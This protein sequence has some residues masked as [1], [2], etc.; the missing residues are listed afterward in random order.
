MN[1]ASRLEA[2]APPDTILISKVTYECVR[3]M[4][5]VEAIAPL[6]LKGKSGP[7][8]AYKVLGMQRR[9]TNS[10]PPRGAI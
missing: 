1:L 9:D 7:V 2:I 4:A 10:D 8:P 5:I 6:Q 3:E